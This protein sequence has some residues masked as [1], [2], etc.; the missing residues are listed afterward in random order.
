MILKTAFKV[1]K[2]SVRIEKFPR[3]GVFFFTDFLCHSM[4]SVIFARRAA[5][6]L[7]VFGRVGCLWRIGCGA[8]V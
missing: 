4:T 3:P 2:F 6:R 8:E 5:R 1:K 7:K